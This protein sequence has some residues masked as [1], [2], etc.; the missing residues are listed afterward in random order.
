MAQLQYLDNNGLISLWN[1]IKSF[2]F[3]NF[4]TKPE[5]VTVSG[6]TTLN[7]SL[8]KYYLITQDVETFSIIFPQ[9]TDDGH[10]NNIV[11][12]FSTGNNPSITFTT[13]DGSNIF[14][15]NGFLILG[16]SQYELNA[17]FNGFAWLLT[18]VKY[19]IE[20]VNPSQDVDEIGSVNK[21]SSGIAISIDDNSLEEG[22][23]TMEYE[24]S[25]G[26]KLGSIDKITEFTI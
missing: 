21:T 15:N 1:R 25:T 20:N 5:I 13:N 6:G 2:A 24:D 10:T 18:L 7:A 22:T 9:I 19:S 11:F 26:R 3:T 16:N 4:Y 12:F 8:N 17:T 23:Y 14:E